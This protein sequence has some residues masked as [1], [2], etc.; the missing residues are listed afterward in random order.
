[1]RQI[2]SIYTYSSGDEA[3]KEDWTLFTEAEPTD[4]PFEVAARAAGWS[5]IS[6]QDEHDEAFVLQVEGLDDRIEYYGD[7]E[8]L[9][10]TEGIVVKPAASPSDS[11]APVAVGTSSWA[12]RPDLGTVKL[13]PNGQSWRGQS[14]QVCLSYYTKAT[15]V[16]SRQVAKACSRAARYSLAD[17]R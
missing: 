7:W 16:V 15:P 9:C 17:R 13:M 12:S 5:Q 6:A 11:A 3:I 8:E 1:L 14:R 10:L 4:S 2:L